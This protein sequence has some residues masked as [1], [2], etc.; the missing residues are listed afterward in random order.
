MRTRAE[1][2]N[3]T[4]YRTFLLASVALAVLAAGCATTLRQLDEAKTLQEQQQYE[5]LAALEIECQAD[6][7]GCNQ[8][9]LLK[10]DACFRISKQATDNEA[11]RQALDCATRELS[12]G[13]SMTKD[14]KVGQLDRPQFYSNLCEASRLRADFGDRPRYEAML[15]SC[16][17][18]FIAFA[19]NDPGAIYFD[20]RA[21]YYQLTRAA[22]PCD[23]LRAL[24]RRIETAIQRF[25]SDARYSQAYRALKT[26][27]GLEL[28]T[29]CGN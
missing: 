28:Q 29:R 8:V 4:M 5:Q 14:W 17:D 24:E 11:K 15:E 20:S 23:G 19:P 2:S 22:N 27:V 1:L 12:T 3:R 26:S 10:G 16:A 7:E 6:D 9:H 18:Q 21:E 13:I 25:Q